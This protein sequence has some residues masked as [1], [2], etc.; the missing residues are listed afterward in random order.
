MNTQGVVDLFRIEMHDTATPPMF[1]DEQ[2]YAYLSDAQ[3]MLARNTG[4]IPDSVSALTELSYAAGDTEFVLD[5]RILKVRGAHRVSDGVP[6]SIINYEDMAKNGLRFDGAEGEVCR[7]IIG[8]DADVAYF[9]NVPVEAG[10]IKLVLDRLPLKDIES[11]QDELEVKKVHHL[12]LLLWM[13][14]LAYDNQDAE[15]FNKSKAVEFE[16]KFN[17]YCAKVNAEKERRKHKT[18]VVQYGG[19]PMTT[20][21]EDDYGR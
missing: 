1:A 12:K 6:V 21:A 4:G 7:L 10:E 15:V 13:K 5:E 16:E 18:R 9:H 14:H 8:M 2:L 20:R 19:L 3:T 17:A 11:E